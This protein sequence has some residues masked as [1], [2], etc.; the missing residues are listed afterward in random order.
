MK[1][2][3]S[4]ATRVAFALLFTIGV[5]SMSAAKT[6]VYVSNA[7]D[8][9]IDAYSMDTATGA[10]TP[11][12]KTEAGKLVMPMTVSPSKKHLYAVIRSQPTRVLTYAIDPATGALAQKASAPLPDSM[13]YV[14]TDHTGRY[15]FTASYG[16]DKLAVSPIG[17]NELVEKEAIQVIPTGRN[18]HAILPDRGNKFVYATTLGANQVLQFT[19]DDKTGKLTPNEPPSVSPDAGHGPRHMAFSSDNKNL[20][21]LNELSGHVTQYAIDTAKGTLTLVKSISSVPA[22]AGL[23]WGAP[24]APAGTAAAAAAAPKEEK[25]KIWAADV[26]ITPNGKFL[27]STERT[28]NKIAL[29]TVAPGTGKLAYVANFATETQPRGIKIDPSGQYLVASGE[30]SDRL[31][32]YKIDQSTGKLGE[33]SRYPVGNGANWVEIVDVQ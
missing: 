28:T 27:Y 15:L 26:Q 14:S 30:K 2:P 31:S 25:P 33:P 18:A 8:G 23:V 5:T 21:V 3:K 19:F 10:L 11:I 6:F 17:E 16:G 13:P 4:A 1:M 9:N 20:Y 12:G 7:Q 29:F 24:Q 22:E 32:V